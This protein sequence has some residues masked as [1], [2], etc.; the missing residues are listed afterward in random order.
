MNT[1]YQP[2]GKAREYSDYAL[3]LY[4]GCGHK[5]FYCYAPQATFTDR[6]KFYNEVKPRNGILTALRKNAP[7]MKGVEVLLSFTSDPYQPLEETHMITREAIKILQAND[8]AVNILT[9]GTELAMRDFDLLRPGID[10]FGT[11]LTYWYDHQS[12]MYEPNASFPYKRLFALE[13]AKDLGLTTWAS[14]EP[15]LDPD[16]TIRLIHAT[17]KFVDIYKVGKWNYDAR[18]NHIDWKK[19]LKDVQEVLNSYGKKFYIKDDLRKYE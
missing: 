19:F 5:C 17:H 12:A 16:Q 9:K 14:M 13:V 11:S 1:I 4:T 6:E 15:V 18:A 10:K 2:R 7:A 8:I 3:N